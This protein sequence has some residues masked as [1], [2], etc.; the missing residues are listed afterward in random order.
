MVDRMFRRM[1]SVIHPHFD[2]YVS[3]FLKKIDEWN[4]EIFKF[5]ELS[6]RNSL[7]H[8]AYNLFERYSL[9]NKYKITK[10]QMHIFMDRIVFGYEMFNN[11]YHNSIHAADVL[12]TT[13]NILSSSGLMNWLN[14]LEIFAVFFAAIIHDFE[15]TGTTNNFHIQ[16]KSDFALYYND[17]AVL[18][19]YHLSAAFK[20]M[21]NDSCNILNELDRDQYKEFRQLVIEIVLATDM[22]FHFAQ[23]KNMKNVM[24][25]GETID[26]TRAL[27]LIIHCADIGHPS[28]HWILHEK[29]THLLMNEFFAQGDK[30]KQLGLPFSPLCDREKTPVAQSQ[31]GFINFIVDPSFI[32]MGDMIDKIFEQILAE[33]MKRQSNSDIVELSKNDM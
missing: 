32:L 7:R 9:M 20:L 30:E 24:N 18:E 12:Q 1:S 19:N 31:I 11:P 23:L 6:E 27:S 16:S 13:F 17:R 2:P 8:T 21:L 5:D 26:K 14:D 10:S 29:W 22:S 4:F 33:D 25:L 3:E 28:K 15:H